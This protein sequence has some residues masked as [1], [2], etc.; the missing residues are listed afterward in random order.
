LSLAYTI[1]QR[2]LGAYKQFWQLPSQQLFDLLKM[3]YELDCEWMHKKKVRR[4]SDL[5]WMIEDAIKVPLKP[6]PSPSVSPQHLLWPT[7]KG[8]GDGGRYD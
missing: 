6:L 4:Y 3:A 8:I 2:D 1:I 7:G 5:S